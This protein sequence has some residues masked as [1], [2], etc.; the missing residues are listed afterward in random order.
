MTRDVLAALAQ[1]W[2]DLAEIEARDIPE[3]ERKDMLCSASIASGKA[4]T[5]KQCAQ[6]LEQLIAANSLSQRPAVAGDRQT[7]DNQR[8]MMTLDEM[9]LVVCEKL[10]SFFYNACQVASHRLKHSLL[11]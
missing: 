11:L 4:S 1:Q 2:R 5:F 9:K 6:E 8:P 10:P 7:M 3:M